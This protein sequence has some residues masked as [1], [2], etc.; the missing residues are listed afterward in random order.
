MSPIEDQLFGALLRAVP[1]WYPVE[2]PDG[3]AALRWSA[4]RFAIAYRNIPMLTYRIDILILPARPRPRAAF[5]L[6][7]ECDGHDFHDRTKQQAAY[8]RA[9]DR[10]LLLRGVTTVRFTGSEIFHS[11]ER[12]A[13]QAIEIFEALSARAS[14]PPS[15]A[16]VGMLHWGG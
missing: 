6:A 2:A 1:G 15:P 9:R 13:L 5:A 16:D 12:C 14:I 4:D 10:E 3:P 11:A 7:V 8:D